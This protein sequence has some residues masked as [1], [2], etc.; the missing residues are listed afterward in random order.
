MDYESATHFNY[1]VDEEFKKLLK[2]LVKPGG[3]IKADDYYDFL[4]KDNSDD[5]QPE[6]KAMYILNDVMVNYGHYMYVDEDECIVLRSLIQLIIIALIRFI[7]ITP[8]LDR[9]RNEASEMKEK[10]NNQK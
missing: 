5:S 8:D 3:K 7:F 6:E 10:K 1:D 2:L 4:V 9:I